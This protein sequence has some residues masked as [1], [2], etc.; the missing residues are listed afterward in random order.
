MAKDQEEVGN[1]EFLKEAVERG[2]VKKLQDKLVTIKERGRYFDVNSPDEFGNTL[3][4]S[5]LKIGQVEEKKLLITGDVKLKELH[6]A[7]KISQIEIMQL[8]IDQGA[9]V[10]LQNK[11]GDTPLHVASKIGNSEV[12]ELLINARAD[13]TLP[14]KEGD[15][16]LHLA[17]KSL[18]RKGV[19]LLV[20]A[21]GDIN[22]INKNGEYA[23][24]SIFIGIGKN[25]I[26][27]ALI[28]GTPPKKLT[29][30]IFNLQQR[31]DQNNNIASLIKECED[32]ARK[33]Q[34]ARSGLLAQI[35]QIVDKYKNRSNAHSKLPNLSKKE[36]KGYKP[37]RSH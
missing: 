34:A 36:K 32:G 29:T 25:F 20:R 7:L 17:R 13:I 35:T 11:E 27:D 4:H 22:A 19:E 37:L 12:M 8:L 10:N 15:T 24:D 5:A 16:P 18:C 21:G 23:L 9:I 3:L 28:K 6:S 31:T 30:I 1:R 33:E 26:G 14:D 2:E